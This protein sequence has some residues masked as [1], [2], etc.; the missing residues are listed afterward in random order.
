MR[1][2]C[3]NRLATYSILWNQ[4]QDDMTIIVLI[5]LFNL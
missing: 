1:K 2:R 3:T 5:D 4:K